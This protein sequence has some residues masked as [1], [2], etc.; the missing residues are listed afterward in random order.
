[1]RSINRPA[2]PRAGG[3]DNSLIRAPS[4]EALFTIF[5]SLK[6]F[7]RNHPW[8]TEAK[9]A[10]AARRSPAARK[11]SQSIFNTLQKTAFFTAAA[12]KMD[13]S[14]RPG[15]MIIAE[16]EKI[17]MLFRRAMLF[18]S[19]MRTR[20]SSALVAP[21]IFWSGYSRTCEVLHPAFILTS[22]ECS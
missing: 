15:R 19:N 22:T 6:Y 5:P 16:P 3:L 8:S 17:F 9:V 2:A 1:V 4:E 12:L 10:R 20:P 21:A 11:L 13:C 18:F 14:H 7:E